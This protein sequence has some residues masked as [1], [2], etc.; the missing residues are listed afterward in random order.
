MFYR[1]VFLGG[2]EHKRGKDTLKRYA[3]LDFQDSPRGHQSR[4]SVT[5]GYGRLFA[6]RNAYLNWKF[7]PLDQPTA[8]VIR[9][10]SR[11][12]NLQLRITLP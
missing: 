12:L 5:S 1:R 3:K 6:C 2:F 8:P 7:C 9:T 10:C 11:H 4:V